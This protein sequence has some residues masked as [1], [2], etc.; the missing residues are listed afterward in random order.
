MQISGL[1]IAM[2]SPHSPMRYVSL[3]QD[4]FRLR[5]II[6]IG[7]IHGFLLG[8]LEFVDSNDPLAGMRGG[9]LS[10]RHD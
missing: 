8:A 7:R 3:L 10:V 5:Q 4:A 9:D 6:R 2:R 1:N